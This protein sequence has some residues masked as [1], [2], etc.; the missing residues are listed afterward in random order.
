MSWVMRGLILLCLL[1]ACA[2]D[3]RSFEVYNLVWMI[4]GAAA[5][6]LLSAN[7]RMQGETL[8]SVAIFALLQLAVF[9]R[10][11]GR[12]DCYAFCVCALTEAAEGLGFTEYVLHMAAAFGL[13]AVVQL[14]RGNINRH[15]NLKEPVA[16]IPYI[17]V[18][19]GL[20]LLF[21]KD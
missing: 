9:S 14:C 16:F 12:A 4:S 18:S 5:A 1:W 17:T 10:M 8:L 2:T 13:L 15:G 11:Y 6:V 3:R 20:I 21:F 7:G 19:F